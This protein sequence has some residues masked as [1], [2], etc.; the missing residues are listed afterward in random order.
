MLDNSWIGAPEIAV[1]LK[2]NSLPLIV[3]LKPRYVV[4]LWQERL[5]IEGVFVVGGGIP[6]CPYATIIITLVWES[7]MDRKC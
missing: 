7:S 1:W 5:I 3:T 2:N 6:V 4:V